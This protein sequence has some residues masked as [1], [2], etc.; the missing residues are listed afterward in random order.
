MERADIYL[1]V[2]NVSELDER[3]ENMEKALRQ[4]TEMF[5]EERQINV[6][7]DG[8]TNVLRGRK[9]PADFHDEAT[10]R[11]L[12]RDFVQQTDVEITNE[13]DAQYRGCSLL[14][15][16]NETREVI[17]KLRWEDGFQN[18]P[19]TS[20][21]TSIRLLPSELCECLSSESHT[22]I[23]HDGRPVVLPPKQLLSMASVQFFQS[24]D[25]AMDIFREKRFWAN[26]ERIY[27]KPLTAEDT[28]WVTCFDLVIILGV[29]V[30]QSDDSSDNFLRPFV[31]NVV[32]GFVSK[33]ILL[34]PELVNV[35]AL[36][37]LVSQNETCR[38]EILVLLIR[39]MIQSLVAQQHFHHPLPE[40]IFEEACIL[41]KH[42]G[43][44]GQLAGGDSG[45]DETRDEWIK[46]WTSLFVRDKCFSLSRGKSS[47]LPASDWSPLL[48]N[49]PDSQTSALLELSKIQEEM[50]ITVY[51]KES[52]L[53]T[54]SRRATSMLGL[55][56]ALDRWAAANN[57]IFAGDTLSSWDL[58][59]KF[60]STRVLLLR[61][62]ADHQHK[63]EVLNDARAACRILTKIDVDRGML[64]RVPLHW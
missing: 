23:A 59:L 52:S 27:R 62:S 35:Q 30:D 5:K 4:L 57:Y 43:F 58:Q 12:S 8:L 31:Q 15:L 10:G 44:D 21:S 60:R 48:H 26:V 51:S 33:S 16:C 47:C 50:Y 32:R 24:R 49:L 19:A 46:V 28:A 54:S 13:P 7:L 20:S 61:L 2:D 25:V 29:G 45:A 53:Q 9:R 18:H 64:S 38:Y 34:K 3:L 63:V 39:N 22:D 40:L 14:S 17:D 36:A 6:S 55:T 42:L 41:A 1:R 11:P 56:R 37:L